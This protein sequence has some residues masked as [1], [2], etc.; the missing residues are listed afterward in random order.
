MVSPI[1]P[2]LF[3]SGPA[4]P[5]PP[6]AYR[7]PDVYPPGG[8]NEA[9]QYD[10]EDA[11]D[12]T[13]EPGDWWRDLFD[14]APEDPFGVPSIEGGPG[15]PIDYD[16]PWNVGA[17]P[18]WPMYDRHQPPSTFPPAELPRRPFLQPPVPVPHEFPW[19]RDFPGTGYPGSRL[20]PQPR[21][22][23]HEMPP[24]MGPQSMHQMQPMMSPMSS[25]Q[26]APGFFQNVPY[27]QQLHGL[28][29]YL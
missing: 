3:P 19:M 9:L 22:A 21:L 2:Q 14:I 26:Q 25:V 5:E 20:P 1:L 6:D 7:F 12:Y 18:S 10:L 28:E 13:T 17:Y 11:F 23:P 8:S 16:A 29:G 4:Q 27:A 15:N 24:M